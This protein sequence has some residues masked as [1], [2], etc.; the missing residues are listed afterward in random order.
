MSAYKDKSAFKCGNQ[1]NN[2]HRN[3]SIAAKHVEGCGYFKNNVLMDVT[4]FPCH[5]SIKFKQRRN[6]QTEYGYS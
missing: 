4:I 3:R 1:S 2:Q 6:Q 5:L